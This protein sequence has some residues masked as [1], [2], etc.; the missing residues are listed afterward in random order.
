M[1]GF[2]QK[3]FGGSKSE[4]DVKKIQPAV[5]KINQFFESYTSLSN[6]EL[7]HKTQEF[8]QR[9]REHL[10][11]INAEIADKNKAA[12]ELPFNDLYGKDSIYQEVDKL[13]KER[14]KKIEEILEQILPE[15]FAVVKR[16]SPS[17][18]TKHRNCFYCHRP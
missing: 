4:K 14:D 5:V 13:K 6:D 1:F 11:E 2:I 12:D 10:T 8:R 15:A 18:F 16:N 9:I 7:R 17:L 3:I